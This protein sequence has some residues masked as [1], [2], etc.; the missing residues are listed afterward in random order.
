MDNRQVCPAASVPAAEEPA[1]TCV[2][3]DALLVFSVKFVVMLGLFPLDGTGKL[4]AALPMFSTVTVF[5]LSLL[6]EPADVLAKLKLGG[7]AKFTL[8]TLPP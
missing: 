6:V 7:L 5:G 4:N 3:E 1:L 8:Y 2:H